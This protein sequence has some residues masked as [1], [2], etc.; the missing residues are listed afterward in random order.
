MKAQRELTKGGNFEDKEAFHSHVQEVYPQGTE[1]AKK[2]RASDD[3]QLTAKTKTG[4]C[5]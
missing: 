2:S 5:E 1:A 3:T 4:K